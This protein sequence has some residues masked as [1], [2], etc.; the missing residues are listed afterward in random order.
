MVPTTA[1][2]QTLRLPQGRR[3]HRADDHGAGDRRPGSRGD[4]TSKLSFTATSA[5]ADYDGRAIGDVTVNVADNE[6]LQVQDIVINDGNPQRSEVTEVSVVFNGDVQLQDGAFEVR[7]RDTDEIVALSVNMSGPV[8]TLS[9]LDGPSVEANDLLKSLSDGN[10]ELNIKAANV[11]FGGT[12]LDGNGDG[13]VGDDYV[14]GADEADNFFRFFGD[15]NGDRD[16][17]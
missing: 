15:S 1:V 2:R 3:D 7:N 8:V 12:L 13:T 14:F 10:Y 4:D 5:D 17:G 9:F 16:V 6:T 11:S